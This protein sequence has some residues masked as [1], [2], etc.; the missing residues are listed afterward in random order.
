MTVQVASRGPKKGNTTTS[1]NRRRGR[2]RSQKDYKQEKG[3]K[4]G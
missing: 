1:G 2:M 4:K 3:V